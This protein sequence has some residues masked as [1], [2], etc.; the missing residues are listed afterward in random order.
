MILTFNAL[1][2]IISTDTTDEALRQGN[3]GNTL[4]AIFQG[5]NNLNYT[6][7][8]AFTR[9]D[10]Q[11]I[12]GIQLTPDATDLTKFVYEFDD[13]WFFAKDG[14][15]TCTINLVNA[16]G[17]VVVTGQ[18]T[19]DIEKTDFSDDDPEITVTQYNSI[20]S[21]LALKLNIQSGIVTV[22]SKS[23]ITISEYVDGQMFYIKSE[24]TL[25]KNN[26]GTLVIHD[27]VGI[28]ETS[29]LYDGAVVN[30]DYV[31]LPVC[32]IIHTN[33]G[34]VYR[35]IK[36]T[37]SVAKFANEFDFIDGNN[38]QN[39]TLGRVTFDVNL[40]T[41]VI[42]NS[43]IYSKKI[44]NKDQID[45]QFYNKPL[46][47]ARFLNKNG[48]TSTGL[49]KFANHVPETEAGVQYTPNNLNQLANMGKVKD[50]QDN[51]DTHKANKANPHEVSKGQV[52]LGNVTN[53]AQVKRTEMGQANG[54]ATLGSN[55][56]IPESQLP[57]S[58]LGQVEYCDDFDASTGVDQTIRTPR[59]GDYYICD[60][61]GT[62][63]P[64]GTQ[65]TQPLDYQKGD[66]AIYNGTAWKKVDNTDA[67]Q[68]VNGRTGAVVVTKEDVGLEYIETDIASYYDDTATYSVGD[69]VI[70]QGKLYVANTAVELPESFD[71][72][73][74]TETNVRT[75]LSNLKS[76]VDNELLKLPQYVDLTISTSDSWLL[77]TETNRYE[78]SK[79]TGVLNLTNDDIV[80]TLP[81]GK[82]SDAYIRAF[83]IVEES[84]DNT[85]GV[86]T[87]SCAVEPTEIINITLQILRR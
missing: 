11:H 87:F 1:G 13:P 53:D 71:S 15:T 47:N 20:M 82:E 76:F 59:K 5:K 3:V 77:N 34:M 18:F 33:T 14:E 72:T 70:R 85:T 46:A 83:D 30:K 60:K 67:V 9:S 74:W 63:N 65:N 24:K 23:D 7:N 56:K 73:K 50:V 39:D 66:W 64:D 80:L 54:I 22:N 43:T 16:A 58:V 37:G 19:F 78:L 31:G 28:I 10:G 2:V 8:I 57:D 61:A 42:S 48:D 6:A 35:K 49:I 84:F 21:T 32:Y 52:G 44:Y 12:S 62:Y 55:G 81:N 36:T 75:L 79:P 41:G 69:V 25:Y 40:S 17:T 26:N 27:K 38:T 68:S 4:K 29:G 51:L 45:E 86:V